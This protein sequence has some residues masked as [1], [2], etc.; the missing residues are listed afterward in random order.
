MLNVGT[1]YKIIYDAKYPTP[2]R[3]DGVVT[4]IEG[5]LIEIDHKTIININSIVRVEIMGGDF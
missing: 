2:T 5:D 3:L 4:K 1:K